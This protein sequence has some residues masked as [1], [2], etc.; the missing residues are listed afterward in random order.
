MW[1]AHSGGFS[2]CGALLEAWTSVAVICGFSFP[3]AYGIYLSGPGIELVSY[4]LAGGFLPTEPPGKS[5]NTSL[6]LNQNI[7]KNILDSQE[8]KEL[9]STGILCIMSKS[10]IYRMWIKIC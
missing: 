5:H 7:V 4:A 1:A 2:Y 9:I 8:S 10:G 6:I 3:E